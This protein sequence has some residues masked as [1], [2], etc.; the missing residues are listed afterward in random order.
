MAK[1]TLKRPIYNGK[2]LIIND[3]FLKGRPLSQS[4]MTK[5]RKSPRHYVDSI[6][7]PKAPSELMIKGNAIDVLS[8]YD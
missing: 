5:F 1:T 7:E 4:K 3:E 2:E 8:L 6:V